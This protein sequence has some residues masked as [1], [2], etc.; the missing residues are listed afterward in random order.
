METPAQWEKPETYLED[1]YITESKKLCQ[2]LK[3]VPFIEI[4]CAT[5]RPYTYQVLQH[6][7]KTLN[8]KYEFL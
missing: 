5:S 6:A 1:V 8:S 4:S 3:K 7:S 2:F